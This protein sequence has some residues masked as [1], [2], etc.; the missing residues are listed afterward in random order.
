MLT[1]WLSHE[2]W[3]TELGERYLAKMEME[4]KLMGEAALSWQHRQGSMV[5]VSGF[6]AQKGAVIPVPF[7]IYNK[8]TKYKG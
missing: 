6:L 1:L 3:Q 2:S 8:F 5:R 4:A 7:C